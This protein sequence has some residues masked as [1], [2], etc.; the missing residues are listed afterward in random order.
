MGAKNKVSEK[1][2]VQIFFFFP[3]ELKI[4]KTQFTESNTTFVE[5][6]LIKVR[7]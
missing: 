7:R 1:E 2:E 3:S 6:N 4:S 5:G